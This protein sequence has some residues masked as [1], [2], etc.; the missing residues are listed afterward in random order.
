MRRYS[1]LFILI[2]FI[3]FGSSSVVVA[4][5]GNVDE[6]GGHYEKAT[7]KYHYHPERL[8]DRQRLL[9]EWKAEKKRKGIK[10]VEERDSDKILALCF[11]ACVISV[12][13]F[14]IYIGREDKNSLISTDAKKDVLK[15]NSETLKTEKQI[16]PNIIPNKSTI[17]VSSKQELEN[18]SIGFIISTDDD[19]NEVNFDYEKYDLC[20]KIAELQYD[21]VVERHKHKLEFKGAPDLKS[22]PLLPV[23]DQNI[24]TSP[25]RNRLV[26]PAPLPPID[27]QVLYSKLNRTIRQKV[28]IK[29]FEYPVVRS[30][31]WQV[32]DYLAF[33]YVDSEVEAGLI[34]ERYIGYLL[35]SCGYKVYYHGLVSQLTH[36]D[37][38]GVD[39]IIWRDDPDSRLGFSRLSL[40]Q[41]KRSKDKISKKVVNGFQGGLCSSVWSLF[42]EA[43]VKNVLYATADCTE[44]AR[45]QLRDFNIDLEVRPLNRYD[46]VKCFSDDNGRMGFSIPGDPFYDYIVMSGRSRIH[47]VASVE[48]AFEQGFRRISEVSIDGGDECVFC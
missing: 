1:F 24:V 47:Y 12:I 4:H 15:L 3:L 43:D 39:L 2:Y 16:K 6:R 18:L 36:S 37:D 9:D 25:K 19:D 28:F 22:L 45:H 20:R 31:Q 13:I 21:L 40:V 23:Q 7:G 44:P 30:L 17:A 35:E 41:C 33:R 38:N 8:K 5:P 34:Y 46:C 48:E 26:F 32:D 10:S 29:K 27:F 14:F 42:R 11:W